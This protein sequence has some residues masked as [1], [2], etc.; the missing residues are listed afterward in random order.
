M[1][2][3]AHFDFRVTPSDGITHIELAAPGGSATFET[4][5]IRRLIERLGTHRSRFGWQETTGACAEPQPTLTGWA[6]YFSI[7]TTSYRV[8][9]GVLRD[10]VSPV[11]AHR[12]VRGRTGC[13]P[14]PTVICSGLWASFGYPG[15]KSSLPGEGMMFCLRARCRYL[16]AGF[17]ERDVG[18]RWRQGY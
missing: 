2:G 12:R 17:D 8:S 10:A 7:G 11:V 18:K 16:H 9:R 1:L 13:S 14:I 5:S 3:R 15:R 6:N 4:S